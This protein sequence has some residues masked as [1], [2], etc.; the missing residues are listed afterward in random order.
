MINQK[1]KQQNTMTRVRGVVIVSMTKSIIHIGSVSTIEYM[2]LLASISHVP[3]VVALLFKGNENYI[4]KDIAWQQ[5][6]KKLFK[7]LKIADSL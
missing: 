1:R 6:E 2:K 3:V 5:A 4:S 7:T